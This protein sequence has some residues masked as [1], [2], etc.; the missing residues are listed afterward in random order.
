MEGKALQ[1]EGKEAMTAS[2]AG[3]E[4]NSATW[5]SKGQHRTCPAEDEHTC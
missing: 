4:K 3:R 5:G 2:P 1:A